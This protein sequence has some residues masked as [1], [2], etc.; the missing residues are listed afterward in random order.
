MSPPFTPL[1]SLVIQLVLHL[2][3]LDDEALEALQEAIRHEQTTRPPPVP[4][5]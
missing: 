2:H 3:E 4:P 1:E 5:R